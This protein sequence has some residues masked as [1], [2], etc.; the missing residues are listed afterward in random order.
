MMYTLM[1][2]KHTYT[3]TYTYTHTPTHI[4]V[5][6]ATHVQVNEHT[7]EM[8]LLLVAGGGGGMA[9]QMGQDPIRPNG[10]LSI[11]GPGTSQNSTT[12][13]PG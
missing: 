9:G 1:S 2:H 10:G 12:N 6:K 13:G 7:G 8:S 5:Y 3:H 11:G 4:P